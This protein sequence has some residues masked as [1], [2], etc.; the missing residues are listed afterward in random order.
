MVD[1][2]LAVA[3][4]IPTLERWEAAAHVVAISGDDE[5]WDWSV[6]IDVPWQEV[7]IAEVEGRGI[8]V[9]VLLDAHAEPSGYWG[10]VSPGTYA[11]DIWIG[12]PDALHR[13]YGTLMMRHALDRAFSEH[14]AQEILIDPLETNTDAI[15]FY[16]HLG[17][18]EVGPR[19]FGTD[20][21]LVLQMDRPARL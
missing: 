3:A 9:V 18:M 19:R 5:P 8:G 6:E 14:D 13:G 12:E 4:D 21:C 17:F 20:D 1:L 11:I 2:R 10:D 15:G 16:K 7:W